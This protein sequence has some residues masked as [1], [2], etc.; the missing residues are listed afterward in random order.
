MIIPVILSGGAGTRL[1]P[2]SRKGYPKPFLDFDGSGSLLQKTWQRVA[3]LP[4]SQSPL[5]ITNRDYYFQTREQLNKIGATADYLL[6]PVGRN[7][8][9]AILA[10]ACWVEQK[11]GAD[12]VMLVVAADHLIN[13]QD[14]FNRAAAVAAAQAAQ[15][16]LVTFG[17]P[18]VFPHT[19]FGYIQAGQ[20]LAGSELAYDVV[21][22]HEKPDLARAQAMLETGQYYWN[23]GMF[24]CTAGQMRREFAE[25][26]PQ[27]AE[28]VR[29][30]WDT[31]SA[32]QALTDKYFELDAESFAACEDISIDYA[33]IEKSRHIAMVAATFD[34]SD[35]G[36]WDA[37]AALGNGHQSE[38]VINIDSEGCY[39]QTGKRTVA[40][41]GL[42]D[43][44]IVD[45]PDAL[46]VTRK[47][48]AQDV[49]KVVDHLKKTG[50]HLHD[51]HITMDRPWGS[52][53]VLEEGA[54]YKIKRIEVK[55]GQSL[56]L[57][58]H[59][60]RSEHWI[61]V[62]GM[63]KVVNGD[64]EFLLGPNESTYI[65]AGHVH[66]L[67]N[68]GVINLAIIEVQSGQYLEE[69]DIVRFEDNYGRQ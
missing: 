51:V 24:C 44:V 56:S 46:L 67:S 30:C 3:Q 66:R 18:P 43:L 16:R 53:T 13:D 27:L 64:Q 59:H 8:A 29:Q 42:Q 21:S 15:A 47:D 41:I 33:V 1:W 63:A 28:Q 9:P 54:G 26:A 22:F 68:P 65:P 55:P 49:K 34:W 14:G 17:I 11:Y 52:Y 4:A 10:A 61:V 45:T 69:D 20:A 12:A 32:R 50:S 58:M 48:R 6:E 37:V 57:Q 31:S 5:I 36:S 35:I 62:S 25:H 7:T 38:H 2:A 60:H 23:S 39:F 19:G 40:A